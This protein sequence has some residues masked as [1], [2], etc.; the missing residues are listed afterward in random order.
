MKLTQEQIDIL[1]QEISDDLEIKDSVL[2]NSILQLKIE[3]L[4]SEE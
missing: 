2:I 3:L 4:E 1:R